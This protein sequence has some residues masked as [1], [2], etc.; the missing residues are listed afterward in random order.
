VRW[1]RGLGSRRRSRAVK[2]PQ[3]PNSSS[4]PALR[5]SLLTGQVAQMALAVVIS[6][7]LR[8]G[9]MSEKKALP[10]AS[11]HAARSIHDPDSRLDFAPGDRSCFM[12]VGGGPRRMLTGVLGCDHPCARQS[13]RSSTA[14]SR[15][16]DCRQTGGRPLTSIHSLAIRSASTQPR[17]RPFAPGQGKARTCRAWTRA[18]R[19]IGQPKAAATSLSEHHRRHET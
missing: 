8:V 1:R 11:L 19:A 5:Q 3:I 10:G 9:Y 18:P 15:H 17:L 2:P 4:L 6:A 16:P 13:W 12:F 7:P 14:G